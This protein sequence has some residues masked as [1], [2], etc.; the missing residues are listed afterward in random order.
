MPGSSPSASVPPTARGWVPLFVAVCLVA[1]NM[2]MTITG[3]GPLLDEIAADQGVNPAA[4]GALASVPLLVWA[5]ISPLAQAIAERIGLDAT[6]S[7]SLVLLSAASVWRSIPGAMNL[8]IGTALIG[9]ALAI[10]NVLIPAA[11]KR[12]F[13]R[14]VPLVMG[15]YSALIGASGALGAAIVAPVAHHETASGPLGWRWALVA[16][17]ATVPVA[18][19]LWAIV[20]RRRGSASSAHLAGTVRRRGSSAT[21]RVWRDP[22]AWCIACYMGS[23]S[24]VFYI[25]ATWL[26]PIDVSHGADLVTAGFH[27]TLFHIFGIL[28]SLLAPVLSRGAL[29]RLLP[30]LVPVAS[31]AAAA[32]IVFLPGLLIAWYVLGGLACGLGL[33]LALTVIAQRS[34]DA[35]TAGAVS[36]MAQSFGYLLAAVGPILFGWLYEASGSW[37]LPLLAFVIGGALQLAAGVALLRERMALQAGPR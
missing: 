12:D 27:V 17:A 6:V 19:V 9:A 29:T 22:V 18:L 8:W 24:W 1:V 21:W 26:S 33:S 23:Q 5:V 7:W 2:R 32:G 36:G 20:T 10:T 37:N 34:A 15:V 3:V 35:A 25:F 28:G 16:T 13:G 31:V 14:R 30:P 11:I 4:L